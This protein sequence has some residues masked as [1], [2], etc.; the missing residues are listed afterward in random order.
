ML[1]PRCGKLCGQGDSRLLSFGVISSLSAN[2]LDI[3]EEISRKAPSIK[4]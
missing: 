1:Q 3:F 2:P 4:P